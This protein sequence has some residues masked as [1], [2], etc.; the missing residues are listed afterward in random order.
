MPPGDK[1]AILV[2]LWGE[3]TKAGKRL[4]TLMRT[5]AYNAAEQLGDGQACWS[6]LV[7][8]LQALALPEAVRKRTVYKAFQALRRRMDERLR[9]FHV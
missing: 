8:S 2:S 1:C 7:G 4:R 6:L 9:D 3:D 5:P